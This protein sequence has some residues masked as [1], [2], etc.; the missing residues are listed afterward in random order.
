MQIA[1]KNQT[2]HFFEYLY[3]S[4]W[5]LKIMQHIH[6]VAVI[7]GGSWATALVK[8]LLETKQNVYWWM[9]NEAVINHIVVHKNNPRYLQS[10]NLG[11]KKNQ[12]SSDLSFVLKK[13]DIIILAVPAAFLADALA[14]VTPKQ[15]QN[16]YI[17]SAIKGMIP[18]KN[19]VIA[20]FLEEKFGVLPSN[21]GIISGPCHAEEVAQE[22]LSYL[23]TASA[24]APFAEKLAEVLRCRYIRA[25]SC[26]DVRGI[27]YATVMKNI[28]ALACG[29]AHGAGYGDNFIAALIANAS[30]EMELCLSLLSP[31]E[32]DVNDS[33]YLGDLLVTAY[34]QFSRN[35]TF[36]SMIGKG[37]SVK[38]AQLEMNMVA[39]GYYAAKCIYEYSQKLNVDLPICN[40]VYRIL[41]DKVSPNLEMHLLAQKLS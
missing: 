30:Q 1:R 27:E 24:D 34:S 7:G 3:N 35:R 6:N 11:I 33:A 21:L 23:T 25:K 5:I 40:A 18:N 38:S 28:F 13:A 19:Q 36:G 2:K 32:R 15:L 29:I 14:E 31:A 4:K 12:I 41:Y 26:A 17:V 39:E 16:K 20:D 37:Y 9:R 22:K 10:A 8:I